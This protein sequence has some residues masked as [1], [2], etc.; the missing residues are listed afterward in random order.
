M[1]ATWKYFGFLFVTPDAVEV[2][3]DADDPDDESAPVL[4]CAPTDTNGPVLSRSNIE[5][6]IGPWC[7]SLDQGSVSQDD[8]RKEQISPFGSAT[9]GTK[10][11]DLVFSADWVADV[12]GEGC[13]DGPRSTEPQLCKKAMFEVLDTCGGKDGMDDGSPR[14]GGS[15]QGESQCVIWKIELIDK[16]TQT[17]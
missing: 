13:P 14:Y 4:E 7:D 12:K 2:P 16:G 8:T 6:R 17:R 5:D 15:Q 1:Y 11:T 9:P 3:R 10:L